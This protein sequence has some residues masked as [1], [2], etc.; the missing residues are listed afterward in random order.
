VVRQ[1]W[2]RARAARGEEREGGE[3]EAEVEQKEKK[4]IRK[5]R[6]TSTGGGSPEQAGRKGK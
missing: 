3:T 1:R 5:I 4:K 6:E 2:T